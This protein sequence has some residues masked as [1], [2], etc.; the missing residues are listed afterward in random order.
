VVL[1]P[2]LAR[3]PIRRLAEKVIPRVPMVSAAELL[4]TVRLERVALVGIEGGVMLNSA[5]GLKEDA[6]R[7]NGEGTQTALEG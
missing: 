3:G 7:P 5:K 2:P 1:C 4:P 6:K